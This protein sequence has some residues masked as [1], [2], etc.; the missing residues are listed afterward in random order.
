VKT[1]SLYARL[2]ENRCPEIVQAKCEK[3]SEG[4]MFAKFKNDWYTLTD[5]SSEEERNLT[6]QG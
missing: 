2:G 5:G 4:P 6:Y 1:L 3:G